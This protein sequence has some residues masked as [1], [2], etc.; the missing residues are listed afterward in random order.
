MELRRITYDNVDEL[1]ALSVS[2]EQKSF[3]AANKDSLVDAY[4]ALSMGGYAEPFGIYEC[5]S[6]VGFVMFGY[7]APDDDDD[8]D[9]ADGNYCL[10]RLMIDKH[11][12]G[13]GL[14]DLA[15]E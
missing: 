15:M 7:G 13:R 1:L 3:V 2:E 6:P 14:G 10:W 5:G 9:V 8:P 4:I 11:Y 12:Q